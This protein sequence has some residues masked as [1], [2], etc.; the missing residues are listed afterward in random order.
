MNR[1][2]EETVYDYNQSEEE[3]INEIKGNYVRLSTFIKNNNISLSK[4]MI[5][6]YIEDYLT[7]NN[8]SL[9]ENFEN[10]F[11]KIDNDKKYKKYYIKDERLFKI[12]I[13]QEKK[14]EKSD[15]ELKSILGITKT[16]RER[17]RKEHEFFITDSGIMFPKNKVSF[18][19]GNGGVGKTY[20][21]I[22]FIREII[23]KDNRKVFAW[24]S[25]DD[26]SLS[27]KRFENMFEIIE[28]T[29]EDI[30]HF[31][32]N[33]EV[34]DSSS[35]PFFDKKKNSIMLD[36]TEYFNRLKDYCIDKDIIILDPLI[37]FVGRRGENDN[38]LRKMFMEQMNTWR[39]QEN[40]TII[41]IHHIKKNNSKSEDLNEYDLFRGRSRFVDAL[42][43]RALVTFCKGENDT[44][45]KHKRT[46]KIVKN[47]YSPNRDSID[48]QL[49][50]EELLPIDK[51]QQRKEKT[52]NKVPHGISYG[53]KEGVKNDRYN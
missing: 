1:I 17:E 28:H 47:N 3:I 6:N 40:K 53:Y 16:L 38:V 36:P 49:F 44:E 45:I 29:E 19:R 39:K 27:K 14:I 10:E 4:T 8:H 5:Y 33:V 34:S 48:I 25:E 18:I 7:S 30:E 13:L 31:Y 22:R 15:N 52:L 26:L 32:E 42:R 35:M 43:F 20:L 9:E 37:G 51:P 50:E 2:R 24:F 23:K 21:L 12:K 11:M 46:M 41:F